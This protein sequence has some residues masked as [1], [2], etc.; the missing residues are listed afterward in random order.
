MDNTGMRLRHSLA[1]GWAVMP[2]VAAA[3]LICGCGFGSHAPA[4]GAHSKP[5]PV[6]RAASD[7]DRDLVA[8]VASTAGSSPLEMKFA[9]KQHPQPGV[10]VPIEL[11]VTPRVPLDRLFATFQGEDGIS[12]QV[13]RELSAQEHPEPGVPIRH[14]LSVI[15]PQPGIYYVTATVLT[16][17]GADSIARSYEIPVIVGDGVPGELSAGEGTLSAGAAA[18][19]VAA[20]R[21]APVPH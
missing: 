11:I 13:G 8:A 3:L 16:D 20:T 19:G 21:V 15:A 1:T 12:V 14:A 10:A 6:A 4:A 17:A 5:A 2:A 7:A 9:L 18:S